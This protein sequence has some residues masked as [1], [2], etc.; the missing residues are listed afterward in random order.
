MHGGS[1]SN[2][3]T[4]RPSHLF[5]V[6]G[7]PVV[8]KRLP[9]NDPRTI[10]RDIPGLS[11]I[12][13]PQLVPG[14]V[15]H[16]NR[17]SIRMPGCEP[18]PL[19]LVSASALQRAMLFE[20]AVAA[21]QQLIAGDGLID[22]EGSLDIAVRRQREHFDAKIP[23]ALSAADKD[24]S[25]WVARNLATMLGR[26]QAEL[27]GEILV[28]SPSLFPGHQ[29]IACG[30]G[31]FALGTNLIE[32]KCTNRNFSSADYRQVIIYWLLSRLLAVRSKVEKQEWSEGILVNPR[33]NLI[34]GFII[35]TDFDRNNSCW[36]VQGGTTRGIF[37]R[38]RKGAPHPIS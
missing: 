37:C 36:K 23:S 12:L 14:L 11:D 10:A 31:D 34:V 22:W 19:E 1:V 28:H 2:G 9:A 32:V 6:A 17:G 18:V 30:R 13:F 20:I 29:W 16:L 24:V 7:P 26:L 35:P 27:G 3:I 21:A 15:A 5:T 38:D 25:L 4:R 33:L 8:T